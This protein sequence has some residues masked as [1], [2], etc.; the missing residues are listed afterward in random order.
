MQ[1]STLELNRRYRLLPQHIGVIH[2]LSYVWSTQMLPNVVFCR[3]RT[4]KRVVLELTWIAVGCGSWIH[5][6][7]QRLRIPCIR[8]TMLL[9]R[10]PTKVPY[11]SFN[12][13]MAAAI[14]IRVVSMYGKSDYA[15]LD[16]TTYSA[17]WWRTVE[18]ALLPLKRYEIEEKSKTTKL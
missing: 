11:H 9:Y 6:M 8:K 17:T 18:L 12:Y 1:D 15:L 4:G 16:E 3:L 13:R 7:L 2:V 5:Y 14:F 10:M